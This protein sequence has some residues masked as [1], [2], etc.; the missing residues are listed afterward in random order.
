ML[1]LPREIEFVRSD[2]KEAALLYE[3]AEAAVDAVMRKYRVH[4]SNEAIDTRIK[5]AMMR[6]IDAYKNEK[7]G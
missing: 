6:F 7:C 4:F 1:R 3:S 5:S 2:L